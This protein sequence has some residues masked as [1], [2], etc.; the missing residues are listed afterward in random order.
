MQIKIFTY[1]AI[2]VYD[3]FYWYNHSIIYYVGSKVFRLYRKRMET[4]FR[5]VQY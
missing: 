2:V 5:K 1:F 3:K 4:Y